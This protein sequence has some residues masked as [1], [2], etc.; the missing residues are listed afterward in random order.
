M[1]KSTKVL[2]IRSR[3][4]LKN[5][6]IWISFLETCVLTMTLMFRKEA[7]K[8]VQLS[9]MDHLKMKFVSFSWHLKHKKP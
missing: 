4:T 1:A 5:R 2:L 6:H 7:K 8:K 3:K 9:G